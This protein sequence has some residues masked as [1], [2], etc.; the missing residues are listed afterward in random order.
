MPFELSP[1]GTKL[2]VTGMDQEVW[3]YDAFT[4]NKLLEQRIGGWGYSVAFSPDGTKLAVACAE[5]TARVWD[6]STISTGNEI[7][8]MQHDDDVTS[9]AF[10]PDG[11]RLATGS[12]DGTAKVWDLQADDLICEACSRLEKITDGK[13]WAKYCT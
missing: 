5:N 2:A 8:R 9:V 6:I 11:T 12:K 7:S 13:W 10:S 3:I 1:D 4:G